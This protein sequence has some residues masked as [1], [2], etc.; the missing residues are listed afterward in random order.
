LVNARVARNRF[1]SDGR[2]LAVPDGDLEAVDA[3]YGP[4]PWTRRH[5]EFIAECDR[6]DNDGL[7]PQGWLCNH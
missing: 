2:G 1:P 6:C 4:P 5:W 7:T 3:A